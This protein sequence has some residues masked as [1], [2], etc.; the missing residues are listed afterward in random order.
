MNIGCCIQLQASQITRQPMK[1][2]I[3]SLCNSNVAK[4]FQIGKDTT[5]PVTYVHS[6][7]GPL[8]RFAGIQKGLF[9]PFSLE[10]CMVMSVR[11]C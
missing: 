6:V 11:S 1:G 10:A 8:R 2:C 9:W 3:R 7:M 5:L 4:D